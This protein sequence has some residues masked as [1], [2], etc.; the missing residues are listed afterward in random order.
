M[1]GKFSADGNDERAMRVTNIHLHP[2][3]KAEFLS[4]HNFIANYTMRHELTLPQRRQTDATDELL[5]FGPVATEENDRLFHELVPSSACLVAADP[6]H[7][8]FLRSNVFDHLPAYRLIHYLAK[9]RDDP[10][11][12]TSA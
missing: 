12:S 7:V 8:V 3:Q 1:V 2:L 6:P 5:G 10:I 4:E 9:K 11:I